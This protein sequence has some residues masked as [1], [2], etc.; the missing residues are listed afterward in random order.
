[1]QPTESWLVSALVH[2][3]VA[4]SMLFVTPR[5]A[6]EQAI[7]CGNHSTFPSGSHDLV[8][9][10]RKCIDVA[11][12]AYGPSFVTSAMGLGTVFDNCEVVFA[13]QAYDCVHFAGPTGKMHRDDRLG[14]R[15][16]GLPNS[17]SG[18][19]LTFPIDIRRHR[20]CASHRDATGGGYKRPAGHDDFVSGPDAQS[21]KCQFQ[22][23]RSIGHRDCVLRSRVSR[24]FA[25]EQPPLFASPVID[26]P[27]T[28]YG[29][30]RLDF[31]FIEMGPCGERRG[32]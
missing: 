16:N 23:D 1:M 4:F 7:V 14:A 5:P 8:L 18:Y 21:V 20:R 3:L 25:F 2:R 22:C 9:T 29:R 26:F 6:P 10:E 13:R 11:H 32:S 30:D 28:Q 24:E 27:R 17:L 31:I 15:R 12:R 19:G